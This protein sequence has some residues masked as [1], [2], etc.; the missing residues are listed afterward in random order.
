MVSDP[1]ARR[2]A[3]D[4]GLD[5]SYLAYIAK[6]ISRGNPP[7]ESD[8][9]L[10]GRALMDRIL[11]LEEMVNAER[12]AQAR[13]IAA[14]E[15]K[16]AA[17]ESTLADERFVKDRA[18]E[19]L[20]SEGLGLSADDYRRPGGGEVP[21]TEKLSGDAAG[22]SKDAGMRV[23]ALGDLYAGSCAVCGRRGDLGLAKQSGPDGCVEAVRA[24]RVFCEEHLHS[25]GW[26][27]CRACACK[28]VS[29]PVAESGAASGYT[30]EQVSRAI[31]AEPELPDDMPDEV[32]NVM[33]TDRKAAEECLRI[34]VRQAKDGIRN[35]LHLPPCS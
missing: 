21:C 15:R 26:M 25:N 35:R 20:A 12:C 33:S 3:G 24:N 31:D 34:A 4:C 22:D 2:I 1:E 16:I 5:G 18:I 13:G 29:E 9:R 8:L 10:V 32:W 23:V 11:E 28:L 17:L 14:L 30:A 6:G 19:A 27:T 7:L